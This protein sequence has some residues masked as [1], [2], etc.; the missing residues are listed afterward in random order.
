MQVVK[1]STLAA[2][3]GASLVYSGYASAAGSVTAN[4]GLV[5]EYHFR[6][7]QQTSDASASAGL[8]YSNGGFYAG[9]WAA[10]VGDGLEVDVFGGYNF[11]LTEDL[12]ASVGFTTYQYTGDFD[13]EYNEVNLGLSYNMLS[14]NYAIGTRGDDESLG[15]IET[16]Y[17]FLSVT[18]SYQGFYGTFGTYG[19]ETDGEYFE[20]GWSTT[21][22]DFNVG[23]S[24]IFSG[25]DL[26]DDETIYFSIGKTFNL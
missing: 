12:G 15:I 11:N 24:T 16:D 9:T 22:S 19:D 14:V 7:V 1:I 2:A 23:V 20:A 25:S 8:N 3:I 18:L 10:D 17:T 5:S 6:G 13:S 26:S 21:I 4:I